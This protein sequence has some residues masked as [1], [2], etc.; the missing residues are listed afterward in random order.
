MELP[1]VW[2]LLICDLA[3]QPDSTPEVLRL[4]VQALEK[5]K[6]SNTLEVFWAYVPYWCVTVVS[7]NNIRRIY[8]EI[9]PLI[10]LFK[11]DRIANTVLA[12]LRIGKNR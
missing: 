8:I 6:R 9:D 2:P 11:R 7:L 10:L 12:N 1:G 4:E 5:F 3:Y